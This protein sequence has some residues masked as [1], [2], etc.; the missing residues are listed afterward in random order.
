MLL[1]TEGVGSDWQTAIP[2]AVAIELVHN[3]SLIHD[4]IEDNG[5][6]RRGQEA[7]W[8][9]W[10]L[11]IGLNSG[12]AM[13]A[14]AFK[15]IYGLTELL[16]SEKTLRAA[17]LLTT[18]CLLLTQGQHLDLTYEDKKRIKIGDY[19]RM[20]EG[21]TAAL[22]ACCTHMGALI[23]DLDGEKLESYRQFGHFLG[24][25]FQIYDDWLGIWGDPE[26]TGKSACSDLV[27]S[28]QTLPV[29]LGL[30]NSGRFKD[31]WNGLPITESEAIDIAGWL[32]ED[33]VEL[34]VRNEFFRWHEKM[35]E[36]LRILECSE[37]VKS[38]LGELSE[39]LTMRKK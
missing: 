12:D 34:L 30:E 11:P 28:K 17:E 7:V 38:A 14:A 15:S 33:G 36:E 31:R 13:F 21:K 26:Q 1:C 35:H 37:P 39:Q 2:A 25:A 29:L 22:F 23:G 4:D 20:I 8:V 16:G 6:T 32:K 10:G 19:F 5:L 27:E 24:I 9:K 3:F 18:T